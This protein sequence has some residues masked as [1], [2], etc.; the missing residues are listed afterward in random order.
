MNNDSINYNKINP[1]RGRHR[2]IASYLGFTGCLH[3]FYV[4]E[5]TWGIIYILFIW[6]LIPFLAGFVEAIRYMYMTDEEFDKMIEKN[7][8]QEDD[9]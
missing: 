1:A 3:K 7:S 6:T 2:M 5:L 4:R 9:I 8:S